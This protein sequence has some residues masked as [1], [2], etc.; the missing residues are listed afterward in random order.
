MTIAVLFP[1][2]HHPAIEERYASWQSEL[3]LHAGEIHRYDPDE[4]ARDVVA[5]VNAEYVLVISDPL[6]LAPAG[7]AQ[8]L[9][10]ILGDAFAALPV[11]NESDDPRQQTAPPAAYVTLRE[12][13]A[14][15]AEVAARSRRGRSSS[16]GC[17][18]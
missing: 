6:L 17:R 10:A 12:L 2:Y 3:L 11:T 1:H 15:A 8:R 5:E 16:A 7:L 14:V 13:E 4:S 18:S 9:A